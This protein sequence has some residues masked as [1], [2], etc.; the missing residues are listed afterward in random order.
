VTVALNEAYIKKVIVTSPHVPDTQFMHRCEIPNIHFFSTMSSSAS[1]AIVLLENDPDLPSKNDGL[2]SRFWA[3][4]VGDG[5]PAELFL[6]RLEIM[7][8]TLPPGALG[9]LAASRGPRTNELAPVD[10]QDLPRGD[11][12]LFSCSGAGDEVRE[13]FGGEGLPVREREPL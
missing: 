9:P 5:V 4:G 10:P 6:F 7:L 8:L 12:G 3:T 1:L 11:A 2:D 13:F